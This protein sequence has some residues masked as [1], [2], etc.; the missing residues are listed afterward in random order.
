[1]NKTADISPRCTAF[2]QKYGFWIVFNT[3][4]YYNSTS[5]SL[6]PPRFRIEVSFFLLTNC[7]FSSF[8]CKAKSFTAVASISLFTSEKNS[9]KK[10]FGISKLQIYADETLLK[11][12]FRIVATLSFKV[13]W[14]LFGDGLYSS[15]ASIRRGPLFGGSGLYSEV[16]SI[17]KRWSI[18]RGG[19][20]YSEARH[21]NNMRKR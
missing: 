9:L 10:R 18:F 12:C 15:V 16:A 14:P 20:C 7:C 21:I 11:S 6:D 1:M 3:T 2:L 5:L 4:K 17:Q 8:N 13:N 19:G